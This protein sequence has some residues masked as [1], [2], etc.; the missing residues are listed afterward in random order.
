MDVTAE[1][2]NDWNEAEQRVEKAQELFEQRKCHEA[3][4]ELRAAIAINPYNSAWLFNIGLTLDELER[5]DEAIEAYR[6][7]LSIAHN[8]L[9]SMS[10]LGVDQFRT[11]QFREALKTF[12]R[13]EEIDP[14]FEASY[15]H[16]ICAYAELGEHEKA[17]EM[18]YLARLYKDECPQCYYNIGCSLQARK[19][20]DR[21]IYCWQRA[22]DLDENNSDIHLRIAEALQSKGELEQSRRHYIAALRQDP[23]NAD[24]LLDLGDLLTEMDRVEEAGEK[25][26]RAIELVPEEPAGHFCHGA[27]LADQGRN[28]EAVGALNRA[29]Q[30][31]PTFGGVHMRLG[32]LYLDRGEMELAR[33]HLRAELLLHPEEAESLLELANLLMD[34]GESR[35]AVICLRRLVHMEPKNVSGWL[36]LA[37]AYFVRGRYAEGTSACSKA[38]EHEPDNTMAMYNLALAHERKAEYDS[39]LCWIQRARHLGSNDAAL[40]RLE[41]R[42]RTFQKFDGVRRGIKWLLGKLPCL[43]PDG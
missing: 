17:D 16:R 6:E 41:F 14:T 24:I 13:V 43:R 8:D 37:V 1:L 5:F 30:L 21:A 28:D 33:K 9:E 31:D 23:G 29:L 12:E 19:Q 42:V 39:S 7:A 3:L 26:R 36:N 32:E 15:C 4:A 35:Q 22:L 18:F 38:L 2:M 27:W 10:H 11:G 34:A 25:Y 40:T 20:F